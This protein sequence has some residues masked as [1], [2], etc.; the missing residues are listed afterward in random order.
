[1]FGTI[2]E[3]VYQKRSMALVGHKP[4]ELWL[5]NDAAPRWSGHDYFLTTKPQEVFSVEP[6]ITKNRRK[7]KKCVNCVGMGGPTRVREM[8]KI[9]VGWTLNVCENWSIS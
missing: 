9:A 5:V 6:V 7:V 2:Q 3:V 8:T 1:M 4:S